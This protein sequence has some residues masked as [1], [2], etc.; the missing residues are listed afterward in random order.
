[1]IIYVIDDCAYCDV[2]ESDEYVLAMFSDSM[3]YVDVNGNTITRYNTNS[4]SDLLSKVNSVGIVF[5]PEYKEYFLPNMIKTIRSAKVHHT[6]HYKVLIMPKI[7]N[8]TENFIS[9]ITHIYDTM[10]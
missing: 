2:T 3:I 5:S 7:F 10:E 6:M 8:S 4:L 1:M 9:S